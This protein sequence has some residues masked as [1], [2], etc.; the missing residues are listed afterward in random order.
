[1]IIFTGDT[2]G[3]INTIDRVKNIDEIAKRKENETLNLF[4]CGDVGIY[5][6]INKEE[7]NNINILQEYLNKNNIN[8]YFIEGNHDNIP[9]FAS[10][11][12]CD[13]HVDIFP[14]SRSCSN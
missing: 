8:L 9:F 13:K 4:I 7:L 11:Y 1:M 2:H 14:A 10:L 12:I 6:Y 5:F 3:T